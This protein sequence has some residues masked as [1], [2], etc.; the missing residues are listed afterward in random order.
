MNSGK[1]ILLLSILHFSAFS[2]LKSTSQ[3]TAPGNQV[4]WSQPIRISMLEGENAKT[5]AFEGADYTHADHFLPRY[6]QRISLNAGESGFSA[7][8]INAVYEPLTEAEIAAIPRNSIIP[9]EITVTTNVL[10]QR[11][12]L[13]GI[14]SFIPLRKNSS[15]N[16]EKLVAFD[17]QTSP[18]YGTRSPGRTHTYAANSVLQSGTWYKVATTSNG[19]Y[20]L[21]YAFLQGLGIDM[22]GVN[23]QNLRVY[24]N[25]GGMLSELNS[26]PR[27]DDLV[28]N[29]IFVQDDGNGSFDPGEYALF[30]GTGADT[31][32][33]NAAACPKFG[34]QKNLYA[35]SAYYFITF[36]LGPGKRI[37]S[38]ASSSASPTHIVNTFDDYGFTEND[39]VNFIKSGRDW[40]GDYF[41]NMLPTAIPIPFLP[42]I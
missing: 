25:G 19:V 12:Q 23:P 14:V 6:S 7:S 39:N 15:G 30:Y 9:S 10:S 4:K 32:S 18:V 16:Y 22:A 36:D 38:Q 17:L 37:Q 20:K 28:E 31:W 11:K 26:V 34:H 33:Y 1:L 40:Y 2:Q 35:D 42:L 21:S 13:Y 3:K 5:L 41:D 29:A 8:I 27:A 24:G